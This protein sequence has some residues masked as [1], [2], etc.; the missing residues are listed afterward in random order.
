MRHKLPLFFFV[1][2]FRVCAQ[3]DGGSTAVMKQVL[4]R[5]DAL[6]R[7]NKEMIQEIRSLRQELAESRSAPAVAPNAGE[8]QPSVDE[9]LSVEEHRTAEQAQTKVEAA[10]K[11]PIQLDGMLL[12]NAF[13]NSSRSAAEYSDNYN[14]LTGPSA[15]GATVRQTLLGLDFQGPHLPG[16]G[17]INGFVSMD[18][19]GGTSDPEYTRFRIRRAGVSFD[20]KNRSFFVGQDKPLISPYQ[21]DSLAEVG[22]PPLAGAGNLWLWLPQARYEERFHLGTGTGFTA[23]MALMQTGESYAAVPPSLAYTLEQA[24]PALEGRFAFWHKFDDTRRFE[25]AP[26]FHVSS[27][28]VAGSSVGSHIGSLDWLIIP[29]SHLQLSGIIFSGQNVAN[30]GALGNGFAITPSGDP[31][32]VHST[33]GWAQLAVP[34]TSRLTFNVFSGVED[35]HNSYLSA[36][37]TVHN[38]TYASN[39]MYHL[40]PNV[41]VS[42]EALQMRTRTVSGVDAL[43]NHYDLAIGYL[44]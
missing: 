34:I 40:G 16:D 18:F 20:W 32:P 38:W 6:E 1:L 31:R 25:I 24:R 35:D 3:N 21:P 10:H 28:H 17:T 5:L 9:R 42:L 44:F 8:S 11:F 33:G 39:F 37:S 12:F 41:I 23:Q 30:L 27:T 7:E 4:E 29:A 2:A 19:Y 15:F 36:V 13:G 43:Q 14:L 22:I 26:G